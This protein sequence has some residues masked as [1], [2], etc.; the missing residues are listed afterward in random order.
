[1][2]ESLLMDNVI[3]KRLIAGIALLGAVYVWGTVGFYIIGLKHDATIVDA[4]FM[5]TITLTTV[6]YGEAIPIA[7]NPAAK[8]PGLTIHGWEGKAS[9][10][11]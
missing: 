11:R 10:S 7:G 2:V 4:L 6:G 1:M 3:R 9:H 8:K 5:T